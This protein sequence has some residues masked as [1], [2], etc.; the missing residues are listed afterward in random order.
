MGES[1]SKKNKIVAAIGI[2]CLVLLGVFLLWFFNGAYVKT[3]EKAAQSK[4]YDYNNEDFKI[5]DHI[6]TIIFDTHAEVIF[7]AESGCL[8]SVT[9]DYN[10][11]R[12]KWIESA[13][14]C[15]DLEDSQDLLS[16]EVYDSEGKARFAY[17]K[18]VVSFLKFKDNMVAYV[19][20]EIA[21]TKHYTVNSNGRNYEL[22]FWYR[23][24]PSSDEK[25][26]VEYRD[27]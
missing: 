20:G 3:P 9:C 25:I 17:Y 8:T 10:K 27:K 4:W 11:L 1:I 14:S 12:S 21:K 22:E 15:L 26:I 24:M 7:I 16:F 6:D 19:N 5:R 13:N 18:K 2:I 23:E